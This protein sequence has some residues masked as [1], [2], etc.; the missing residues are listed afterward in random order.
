M[1]DSL[2][3]LQYAPAELDAM[4]DRR[5]LLAYSHRLY[6]SYCDELTPWM[7]NATA[8]NLKHCRQVLNEVRRAAEAGDEIL[9]WGTLYLQQVVM[10]QNS[11]LIIRRRFDALRIVESVRVYAGENDGR[12]PNSLMEL[13]A[14]PIRQIDAVTGEKFDFRLR[15]GAAELR[16]PQEY[17]GEDSEVHLYRITVAAKK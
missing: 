3:H 8:E 17:P 2:K 5:L 4:T 11:E 12:L 14:Y 6:Q 15:D 10:L 9:P 16:L 13:S 7:V 1:V